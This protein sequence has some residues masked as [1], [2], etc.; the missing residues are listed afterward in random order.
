MPRVTPH[1][2]PQ[3]RLLS[4]P[5]IFLEGAWQP[6]PKGKTSALLYYLAYQGDWV[7]RDELV[8]LFWADTS[9]KQ[10]RSNLRSL[11]SRSIGKLTYVN[12]EI[13]RERL[14]WQ[15]ES[16]IADFHKALSNNDISSA[17]KLYNGEFLQGYHCAD[18]LAF[19]DWLELERE[20][21]LRIY[22]ENTESFVR[23]LMLDKDYK[24]AAEILRKVLD[25]DPFDEVSFRQ[26]LQA[27]FLSDGETKAKQVFS[28]YQTA[29]SKELET[30]PDTSTFALFDELST[31]LSAQQT[32]TIA[33][34][35]TDKVSHNLPI[36]LTPFIGRKRERD[37]LAALLADPVVRLL[38]IVAPGG[39]G[40]T[41]LAI[42]VAEEHI[43]SFA[44]GV[45]FVPFETL[46][47]SDN[48]V[49]Q[50][51]ESL[52]FKFSGQEKPKQQL[53]R[54]I[55]EKEL[56]L[57]TDNLE[58]LLEGVASLSEL[59]EQSPATKVLATS[60]EVLDLQAEHVFGLNGLDVAHEKSEESE[61]VR[62]FVQSAQQ[63]DK[64]FE[65]TTDN[66]QVVNQI[67][68]LVAGMPLAL[69]LAASWLRVLSLED[70]VEE[71]EQSIDILESQSRDRSDRQQSI[72]TIFDYSWLLLT[73]QE[74]DALAK[75]AVF[76]G[77]FDRKAAKEVTQVSVPILLGL[78]NKSFIRKEQDGRYTQH[79]LMW[80][81]CREKFDVLANMDTVCNQHAQYFLTFV[82]QLPDL[83]KIIETQPII[84][85]IDKNFANIETGWNL[86]IKQ[87]NEFLIGN[88]SY[89]IINFFIYNSRFESGKIFFKRALH[90]LNNESIAQ[91]I[92]YFGLGRIQ[93]MSDANDE[94]SSNLKKSINIFE[95]H[96]APPQEGKLKALFWLYINLGVLGE[97]E[98]SFQT[99]LECNKQARAAND[100][101]HIA[102]SLSHMAW[103]PP[104]TLNQQTA[105]FRESISL[106]QNCN[107]YVHLTW[108]Y[109]NF[110]YL[111]TLHHG[112]Y[113]EALELVEKG[114]KIE[115]KRGWKTRLANF[116][117]HKA[118]IFLQ[119]G[120]LEEAKEI[121]YQVLDMTKSL[122]FSFD[123]WSIDGAHFVLTKVAKLQGNI[124]IAK[125]NIQ[126][127]L[128]ILENRKHLGGVYFEYAIDYICEL[129]QLAIAE[130]EITHAIECKDRSLNIID[131]TT[132]TAI[133]YSRHRL[134]ILEADIALK[135]N[136]PT[137]A[138]KHLDNAFEILFKNEQ[139]P[140]LLNLFTKYAEVLIQEGN[141]PQAAPFLNCAANHSASN[142][143]TKQIARKLLTDLNVDVDKPAE[144]DTLIRWIQDA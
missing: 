67:C 137:I 64:T 28:D 45:W 3:L 139:Q 85:T 86:A 63:R 119:L 87:K 127:A 22:K 12:L 113:T 62:L 48:M 108:T 38:T 42:A 102:A 69:E 83:D 72:R 19:E 27:V 144:F 33:I 60:R 79:P 84:D 128:N 53:Y 118:S 9:E 24:K 103:Q 76:H 91:A 18:A 142:F 114:T 31:N 106:L 40:K 5:G 116:Y 23:D 14:R 55:K 7:S 94:A 21:L 135:Q 117:I 112:E 90:G 126:A 58:H 13:E 136:T 57:V 17:I 101:F 75:L 41:R 81:Y 130:N 66:M 88:A 49:F 122:E 34:K 56:L 11:L 124:G 143:E 32:T 141:Y 120:K 110:A 140:A 16:D 104:Y 97:E 68:E 39:M 96:H 92:L 59:L 134:Y 15:V 10:A 26:Y 129:G 89:S 71:L 100:D 107:G 109:K 44:D 123:L 50:I 95:L 105:M 98:K 133:I 47:N 132:S 121:A 61:A 51:A 125:N 115:S 2:K 111:L 77:G 93:G 138:Y 78:S 131:Q 29:L 37:E 46:E 82:A 70:I 30:T 35:T 74:K 36:K 4:K 65:F 1:V 6:L 20:E 99:L 80:Q 52:D 8:Y 54:Y 73:K 25:Q 43:G